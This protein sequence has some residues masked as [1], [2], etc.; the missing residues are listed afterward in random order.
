MDSFG[1][2]SLGGAVADRRAGRGRAQV[3]RTGVG[4]EVRLH[5]GLL[6]EGEMPHTV[7]GEDRLP[8]MPLRLPASV[9]HAY[10]AFTVDVVDAILGLLRLVPGSQRGVTA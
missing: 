7:E 2:E 5:A 6:A 8:W 10:V 3:A 4:V 1:L 9:N